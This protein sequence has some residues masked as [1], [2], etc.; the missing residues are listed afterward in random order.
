[1]KIP[2]SLKISLLFQDS[3]EEQTSKAAFVLEGSSNLDIPTVRLSRPTKT[4]PGCQVCVCASCQV[5]C[6]PFDSIPEKILG[7]ILSYFESKSEKSQGFL[8]LIE[9]VMLLLLMGHMKE[10]TQLDHQILT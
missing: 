5:N 7:F 4:S 10:G 2:L 6:F 8:V 9:G 1:L 3:F